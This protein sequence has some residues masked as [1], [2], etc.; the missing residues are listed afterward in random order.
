MEP[1]ENMEEAA[2]RELREELGFAPAEMRYFAS[3]HS[4]YPYQ[5]ITY[6]TLC[7][8]YVAKVGKQNIKIGDDV[9]GYDWF[10]YNEAKKLKLA[11]SF[12]RIALDELKS[13]Q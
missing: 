1:A 6:R 9:A 5:K 11:F 2:G 3:Y 4:I 7:V 8:M 13:Y 12:I 10:T